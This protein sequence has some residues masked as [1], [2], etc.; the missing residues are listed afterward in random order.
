MLHDR[1][2]GHEEL[3]NVAYHDRK[4]SED[5]LGRADAHHAAEQQIDDRHAGELLRVHAAAEMSGQERAAPAG[6]ARPARGNGAGALLGAA[7]SRLLL[8]RHHRRHAAPARRA[9][10]QANRRNAQLQRQA[11]EVTAL[12]G[13]RAVGVAAARGEVVGA[14]HRGAPVDLAPST[15][16]VGRR[17]IRDLARLVVRREAG[18]AAHLAERAFVQ[19]QPDPFAARQLPAATLAHDARVVRAGRKPLV[20]E[21]L[22]RRHVLQHRRPSF[23]VVLCGPGRRFGFRC[24]AGSQHHQHLAGGHAVAGMQGQRGTHRSRAR[25]RDDRLHLHRIDDGQRLARS[26][27]GP[28]GCAELD[29]AAR[30][31]TLHRALGSADVERGEPR[32]RGCSRRRATASADGR[33][34]P[35]QEGDGVGAIVLAPTFLR[36]RKNRVFREQRRPGV[37]GP[38]ARVAENGPQ[39]R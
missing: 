14:D 10:Q 15:D 4:M 25:R 30:H 19:Q 11:V 12:G 18:H 2:A 20:G 17:E 13:D 31:R 27:G 3:R 37:A 24:V 22:H 23:H 36:D 9:V 35:F 21:P 34:L 26:H 8:R 5:R 28:H 16:H 39:H 29:Q 33:G 7:L 1:R 32:R 38:H 6:H